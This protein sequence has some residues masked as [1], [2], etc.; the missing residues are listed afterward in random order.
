MAR[1]VVPVSPVA[2]E[3]SV[4][5]L[6]RTLEQPFAALYGWTVEHLSDI[7]RAQREFDGRAAAPA[8]ARDRRIG[9]DEDA[10]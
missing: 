3:Y 2:V 4:T 10:T 7:E 5:P 6:G 1:R 8:T 9:L